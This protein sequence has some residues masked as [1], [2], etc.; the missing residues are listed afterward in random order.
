MA[1]CA[2][3]APCGFRAPDPDGWAE[4]PDVELVAFADLPGDLTASMAIDGEVV[5]ETPL[6][7]EVR[8][9]VDWTTTHPL[10][11]GPHHAV[12]TV[13]RDGAPVCSADR[14]FQVAVPGRIE[15]RS[16]R[17][18]VAAPEGDAVVVEV[19]GD[20]GVQVSVELNGS[21]VVTRT[22][23]D[24]G[25]ARFGLTA[26]IG[27][28]VVVARG[29]EPVTGFSSHDAVSFRV[30]GAPSAPSVVI[31]PAEP[32]A[33]QDLVAT[34]AQPAQ[35]P[36]GG[37]LIYRW[38]WFVDGVLAPELGGDRVP[39]DRLRAGQQWSVRGAA[40]DG[41]QV[42]AEA[43]AAVTVLDT[44][45]RLVRAWISPDPARGSDPLRCEVEVDEPDG[46]L[47]ELDFLWR[48]DGAVVADGETWTATG[49][50]RGRVVSCEATLRGGGISVRSADVVIVNTPPT[51][52]AVFTPDPPIAGQPVRCGGV[53]TDVDGDAVEVRTQWMVEGVP[54]A[55]GE[56][57][58]AEAFDVGDVVSCVRTPSDAE[59]DGP[60]AGV[61][62]S[63]IVAPA[64]NV[65]VVVW[66][67]V[68]AS[69]LGLYRSAADFHTPNL[70]ALASEGLV[71]ERAWSMPI[72]G[73]SRAAALTGRYAFRTG[74][75]DNIRVDDAG[76]T[77]SD[78]EVTWA[79]WIRDH[80][81][82]PY[83][84]GAVGKWH[85]ASY[86]DGGGAHVLAQGFDTYRGALGNLYDTQTIDGQSSDYFWWEKTVDT[87][88]SRSSTYITVDET[89][90]AI[91]L[92]ST[93]PEP[94]VIWV[95]YHAAHEPYHEPPVTV[96]PNGPSL[97]NAFGE[98]ERYAHMVESVD[99]EMGRLVAAAP[100][101]T[102]VIVFG[103]N[104][105]PRRVRR[106]DLLETRVKSSVYES[107]VRVP[108][109]IRSPRMTSPGSRTSALVHLVDVFPTI[110]ELAGAPV[111][112][113]DIDGRSLLPLLGD[114][115]GPPIHEVVYTETFDPNGDGPYDTYERAIRDDH[116]KV[117]RRS[118]GVE[119]LYLLE[120]DLEE[121]DDRLANPTAD[122][123]AAW[124]AL[125]DRLTRWDVR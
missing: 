32:R 71:F 92:M 59:G 34:L 24:K 52:T 99:A 109:V 54:V 81:R 35:D 69:D 21:P 1:G 106:P 97:V 77:F 18:G 85:L 11:D 101:D 117:I 102:H 60:M 121:G 61:V 116:Y 15:I 119:E 28:H 41:V 115:G 12:L 114:P 36:E 48:V 27:P 16:P 4:G 105:V 3:E 75:G 123:V 10:S 76:G 89:D 49:L 26:G 124:A 7:R 104:G 66:D 79:E 30:D 57:L 31:E 14:S 39:G 120:G 40:W 44:P 29:V 74:F 64:G 56:V 38:S 62:R 23:A 17:N 55:A 100:G 37:E 47:V 25:V 22:I 67:D 78:D 122:D 2:T 20:P 111:A 113:N 72:C 53:L 6:I 82:V 68:A 80:G 87:T 5:G 96:L 107:G 95:A 70:D 50:S 90:E 83:G 13:L 19:L 43:G 45:T 110:A 33:G 58:G 93:L 9:P 8:G 98:R 65:L 73:P 42:G 112:G 103:D 51:T 63:A 88:V 125:S 118:S 108:F 84:F 86:P 91:G 94:W 46:D